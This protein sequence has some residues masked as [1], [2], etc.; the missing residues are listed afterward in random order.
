MSKDVWGDRF[1][2][3]SNDL[4]TACTEAP[5]DFLDE[6]LRV[7]TEEANT[8]I[9]E[10][11]ANV[12]AAADSELLASWNE[13]YSWASEYLTSSDRFEECFYSTSDGMPVRE[14]MPS[15]LT[16]AFARHRIAIAAAAAAP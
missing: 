9:D 3:L 4:W 5:V 11:L 16:Q 6:L 14:G 15:E 10:Y 12:V 1:S 2:E 8:L 7:I 13:L